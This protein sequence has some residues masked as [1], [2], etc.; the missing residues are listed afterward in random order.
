M[1]FRWFRKDENVQKTLE[2]LRSFLRVLVRKKHYCGGYLKTDRRATCRKMEC[3][4]YLSYVTFNFFSSSGVEY[5][6]FGIG[7]FWGCKSRKNDFGLQFRFFYYERASLTGGL[8][9]KTGQSIVTVMTIKTQYP[10]D[11]P[12]V[13]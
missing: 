1:R 3:L 12:N 10:E 11:S 2:F 4:K 9:V 7:E 5:D 6:F 13:R 8:A